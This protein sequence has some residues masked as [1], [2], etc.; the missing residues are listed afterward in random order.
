MVLPVHPDAVEDYGEA[1]VEHEV[2]EVDC[3]ASQ[4]QHRYWIIIWEQD[5]GEKEQSISEADVYSNPFTFLKS[6]SKKFHADSDKINCCAN[7]KDYS[8]IINVMERA[9][10][11]DHNTNHC[12][13]LYEANSI[14]VDFHNSFY[15]TYVSLASFDL[16]DNPYDE[17][18]YV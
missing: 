11:D 6:N 8:N 17:V 5:Q 10:T 14:A 13:C 16:D 15:A 9:N 4:Q 2:E 1:K 7:D 18:G 3:D 12:L